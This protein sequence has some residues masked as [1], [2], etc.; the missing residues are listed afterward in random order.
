M[1]IKAG[2]HLPEAKIN[3]STEF[4][5]ANGCPMPPQTHDVAALTKGEK[6]VIFGLP[7]AYSPTCKTA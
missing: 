3:E 5:P 2:D 7:G 4:D 1:S 6:I